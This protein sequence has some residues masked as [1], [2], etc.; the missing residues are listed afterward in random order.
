[1]LRIGLTGGIA[2]G[3]SVVARRLGELGAVL[4]DADVLARRAAEPG[5]EG[6]REVIDA[7]GRGILT[8]NGELDR[9][10]LGRLIFGDAGRE[11]RERLNAIIHP[12]VRSAAAAL[13]GAAPADAVVIEDIPLLVETGQAPRF[14]LVIVVDAPEAERVRRMVEHRGMGVRDAEQ[15]IRAQVSGP[16]R[17]RHADAVLENAGTSDEL[18]AATDALWR[19]RL[20][21]FAANLRAGRPSS[22]GHRP[23]PEPAM[24][25]CGTSGLMRRVSAKLDAALPAGCSATFEPLG[26]SRSDDVTRAALRITVSPSRSTGTGVQD[27]DVRGALAAAG[28][29]QVPDGPPALHRGADPATL[30]RVECVLPGSAVSDAR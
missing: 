12:R 11:A 8:E 3:K 22:G 26:D 18:V 23:S 29:P 21:P 2:A 30:V 27:D 1:M 13:V 19:G 25:L 9:P 7:F 16:D 10:A 28:F 17:L 14:H 5:S 6:L 24:A 20:L 15:R 4:V